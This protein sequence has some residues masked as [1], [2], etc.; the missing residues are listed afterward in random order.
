MSATVRVRRRQ[1]AMLDWF[2][3]HVACTRCTGEW[4]YEG[5]QTAVRGAQ[6]HALTHVRVRR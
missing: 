4:I 3:W 6:S 1:S 5:H 2:W